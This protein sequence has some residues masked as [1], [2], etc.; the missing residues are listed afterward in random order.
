MDAE[1]NAV[2]VTTTINDWFGSRVTADG[3]GFLLNDEMDDFSSKPGVP[4]SDGLLQGRDQC[5]WA[6][7][8]SAVVDDSYDRGA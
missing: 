5:N 1:G 2:S 3:L 4:N 6:G 7:E 8:A